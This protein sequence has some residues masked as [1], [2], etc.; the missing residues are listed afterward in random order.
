MSMELLTENADLRCAHALGKVSVHASQGWVRIEGRRVLVERDPE[1]CAIS[2]C[3]NYGPTIKPCT[4]TLAVRT[5]YSAFVRI[6]GH[7]I[8]L[9]TVVGLTDGTPPGTVQY[10]VRS[11]GQHCVRQRQP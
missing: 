8:C 3:P 1:L 6:D 7:R 9:D 11:S 5:G 2:G 4:T 10:Q